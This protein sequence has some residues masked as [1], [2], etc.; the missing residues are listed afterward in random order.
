MTGAK[1]PEILLISHARDE[2]IAP[3]LEALTARGVEAY[4]FDTA[5]YP[6]SLGLSIGEHGSAPDD[7]IVHHDGQLIDLGGIGA[8]WWRRPMPLEIDPAVVGEDRIFAFGEASSLLASCWSCLECAWINPPQA[9]EV[10]G[11]KAHQLRVAR[12]V[13]LV[14]PRTL[15]TSDPSAARSFIAGSVSGG[16][17]YKTFTATERIWRETR[18]LRP[19]EADSLDD[20]TLAPVIFQDCVP[21]NIDL[22]IIVV[23][24]QVFAASFKTPDGEYAY[25]Y[26]LSIGRAEVNAWE[27]PREI[28][29]QLLLL[30][31]QLGL[32][33]G[34]IDM[35]VTPDGQYVFLEVNPSGQWDFVEERTGQPIS[36]AFADTLISLSRAR[37]GHEWEMRREVLA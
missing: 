16:T 31:K 14:V 10:A 9:D 32:V 21:G 27:L 24:Q 1:L 22:R 29:A 11:R 28:T 33:Y 3:V 2:H 4:L 37:N 25:D 12:S 30:M 18:L 8:A 6:Q 5:D 13:G 17:I 35:R 26:R 34:A 20:L 7:V 19:E 36:Q 15:M 23:G